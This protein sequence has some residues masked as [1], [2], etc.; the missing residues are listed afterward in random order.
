MVISRTPRTPTRVRT[1]LRVAGVAIAAGLLAP[2]V[3]GV[4]PATAG[5]GHDGCEIGRHDHRGGGVHAR[6]LTSGLVGSLGSAIGPDD[7]LYVT[8]GMVGRIARIDP[9]TGA[10]TTLVSGLPTPPMGGG[11]ANDVAFVRG[12]PYALVSVV[13]P[14][15]GGTNI[16]GVYRI[17]GPTQATPVADIGAWAIANPPRSSFSLP[18]GVQ[19]AMQPYHGDLLVTD[20][21]HNRV[22]RVD[23]QGEI[24]SN[25]SELVAFDNVV[26][27]GIDERDGVVYVA[28][29]G[30]VPHLPQDGRVVR[31]RVH[32]P[33][34]RQ[35][36]SG[37]PLLVDV[38]LSRSGCLYA[39]SQGH[40]T[41]GQSEGSPAD[42]NTGSLQLVNRGGAMTPVFEGLDQPTSMEFDNTRAYVVTL[43]GEV[44]V[45]EGR[46]HGRS[47]SGVGSR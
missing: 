1:R 32:A 9:R 21:H 2:G 39:L 33:V 27:T 16:V 8:E 46:R 37:A 3:G 30:P 25:V 17:D 45:L 23:L 19:F 24:G 47:A 22:L 43:G 40:F 10:R 38:E 29:A 15:V 31:F 5:H 13:G 36:A 12:T 11:G 4:T 20:G 28:E 41:P 14:D 7:A 35:V 18:S 34:A 42:P 44:W 26:S 6:V